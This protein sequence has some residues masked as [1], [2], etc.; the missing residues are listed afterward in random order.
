[1]VSEMEYLKSKID[2]GADCIITQMF[3]D[4]NV[5]DSFVS[6]CR[7][8]GITVPIVPGIMCVT[9]YGGFKRMTTICKTRVTRELSARAIAIKDDEEGFKSFGIQLGVEMGK[10]LMTSKAPGML[11]TH[12]NNES[13]PTK[14]MRMPRPGLHFYTLNSSVATLEIVKSLGLDRQNR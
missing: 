8:S 2:A 5:Y 4:C 11:S 9:N 10:H 12:S 7:L 1:M 14:L 3:F 6:Q 13:T